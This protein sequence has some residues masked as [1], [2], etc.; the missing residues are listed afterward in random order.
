MEQLRQTTREIMVHFPNAIA[1][2]IESY[3]LGGLKSERDISSHAYAGHWELTMKLINSQRI[4]N[5]IAYACIGD[6]EDL[7]YKL[8]K[9]SPR[10]SPTY[11]DY[12]VMKR[13]VRLIT[14]IPSDQFILYPY[15]QDAAKRCDIEMCAILIAHG[16]RDRDNVTIKNGISHKRFDM[17][18]LAIQN[19]VGLSSVKSRDVA[20]CGDWGI[21]LLFARSYSK[22]WRR[23]AMRIAFNG[24]SRILKRCINIMHRLKNSEKNVDL[25]LGNILGSICGCRKLNAGHYECIKIL[26]DNGVD[27]CTYCNNMENHYDA[28]AKYL[29]GQKKVCD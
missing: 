10:W 16:V 20:D 23:M 12:A 27:R 7:A 5:M 11:T 1:N 6:N 28:L 18:A 21:M 8:F 9:L 22:A 25:E 4:N 2:L 17:I 24:N 14:S 26:L 3:I 29:N 15:L 19:G 13:S